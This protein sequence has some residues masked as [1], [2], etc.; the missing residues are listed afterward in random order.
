MV[1]IWCGIVSSL[2]IDGT[3]SFVAWPTVYSREAC[4]PNRALIT[5]GTSAFQAGTHAV[6]GDDVSARSPYGFQRGTQYG[7]KSDVYNSEVGHSY[8]VT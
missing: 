1:G 5:L 7:D 3:S 6:P 4:V 8:I 2:G